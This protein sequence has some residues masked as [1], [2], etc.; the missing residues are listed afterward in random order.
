[1]LN[2]SRNA[3]KISSRIHPSIGFWR[4]SLHYSLND[5]FKES[6]KNPS[7]ISPA[8]RLG[9]S[10]IIRSGLWTI[11]IEDFSK[12]L[13]RIPVQIRSGFSLQSVQ[14]F[15][16]WNLS[17]ISTGFGSNLCWNF[18]RISLEFHRRFLLKSIQD[19]AWNPSTILRNSCGIS[20]EVRLE[21]G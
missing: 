13:F 8:I 14:V 18:S 15:F 20:P 21:S 7:L 10:Q 12:N 5:S 3:L 9:S 1:M 11:S 4:E 6:S 2:L 19:Y 17:S 16:F